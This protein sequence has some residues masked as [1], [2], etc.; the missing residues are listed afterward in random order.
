M[1]LCCWFADHSYPLSYRSSSRVCMC[2]A[3]VPSVDCASP[4]ISTLRMCTAAP[5]LGRKR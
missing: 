5:K 3:S 2:D 1:W 4:P